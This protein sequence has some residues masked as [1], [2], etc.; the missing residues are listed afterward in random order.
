MTTPPQ[1]RVLDPDHW[2]ADHGQRIDA[3]RYDARGQLLRVWISGVSLVYGGLTLALLSGWLAD[4]VPMLAK[5]GPWLG[6]AAFGLGVF[7]V[8]RGLFSSLCRE[9]YVS[10]RTDG[11]VIR[12]QGAPH[13]LSWDELEDVTAEPPHY[14]E[15]SLRAGGTR[16]LNS[17][18]LGVPATV[19][20]QRIAFVRRRALWGFYAGR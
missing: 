11:I 17:T 7:A 14:V 5:W 2:P 1:G 8:L 4:R 3:Y 15:L 13:L 12:D 18:L 10:L 6:L 9:H 16:R 20:A 19:L